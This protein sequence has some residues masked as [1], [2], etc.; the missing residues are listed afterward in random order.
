VDFL[1]EISV[2]VH[3]LLPS[4]C[5][6]SKMELEGPEIVIYT[7]NIS[8]FYEDENL[9]KSVATKLKKRFI[10][11]S[12]PS[13]LM[14]AEQALEK[15]KEIVPADANIESIDFDENFCSVVMVAEKLGL[16]IGPHG[17]ILKEITTKTG[18]T[19]K[20][21]RKPANNC[22][23]VK[24]IRETLLKD[25][26]EIKKNLKA[27]GKRIYRTPAKSTDWIRMSA[28]G[29]CQE[30]GRSC[31]LI[32]TPES[33]V[34]LDCGVNVAA[35][36]D[37]SFPILSSINFSLDELDAVIISHG[38][39]DHSGFLPYLYEYGYKGPVY[40]TE[41][42]RDV[43]ALLQLD[44]HKVLEK[45]GRDAP[46]SEKH[47]KQE[48]K[49]VITRSYGEVTDITPDIRLTLYNAGHLLGS[50]LIHLH[51]GEGA[52][53]M[54]YTGDLNFGFTELFNSANTTFPRLETLIIESTYGGTKARQPDR[55]M[56]EQ[57]LYNLIKETIAKNGIV[58]IPSFAVGRAQE[59]QLVLERFSKNEDW[60]IPVYLDGMLKQAS[61]MHT[62]YPEYLRRG[63]Q[64]R[65]L[66]NNSPFESN[67]FQMVDPKQ[68]E[69]IIE[70]GRCV[71][72]ASSGM[73]VG[74][75]IIEYFKKTC[76]NPNN[77]IVFVGYQAVGSLGRQIQRGKQTIALEEEG[78]LREFNVKMNVKTIAGFSGHADLNQLLGYIKRLYPKPERVLTVH[79]EESSCTNLSRTISYKFRI[80]STSPRNLD[81]I[82]LK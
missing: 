76:E 6:I 37:E 18:W 11:R 49:N 71:I 25:S 36:G 51:I 75:P 54:L 64:R 14:P 13:C 8:K 50:S 74:G 62:I 60:D 33:K 67:I 73:M 5:N 68:R 15:I 47:I 10:L 41:P 20:L 30:V 4:D 31:L 61:A 40:C 2:E 65:I 57:N 79:G 55:K 80:D 23:V 42:T 44:Y 45:S 9:I 66:H 52:H 32:E 24:G 56:C 59:I 3:K 46:Y 17:S 7:K 12:D 78:K 81:S 38:H 63:V 1:K 27:V 43:M 26:K 35:S 22:P 16:I 77:A 28:L 69:D 21:L 34:L 70:N 82:R 48:I 19:P 29:G 53:N 72:L 58:I 39:L